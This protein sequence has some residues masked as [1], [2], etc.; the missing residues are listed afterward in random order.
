MAIA[1]RR[2]AAIEQEVIK[3]PKWG[4]V[5][6]DSNDLKNRFS[7]SGSGPG[8]NENEDYLNGLELKVGKLSIL[9]S[10]ISS[11]R[12]DFP[13]PL[14]RRFPSEVNQVLEAGAFNC[15]SG[16]MKDNRVSWSTACAIRL[17]FS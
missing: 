11:F 4:Y 5:L 8:R 7:M 1:R 6:I 9:I 13:K 14:R 16:S 15:S 10:M 17:E 3:M 12:A 2:I